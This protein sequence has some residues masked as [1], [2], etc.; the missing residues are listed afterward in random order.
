M[1]NYTKY[2]FTSVTNTNFLTNIK[3]CVLKHGWVVD[4]DDLTTNEEL[5]LHNTSNNYYSFKLIAS[6][7]EAQEKCLIVHGNTGFNETLAYDA[8]PGKFTE[9]VQT[10]NI[11]SQSN[12]DANKPKWQFTKTFRHDSQAF[13]IVDIAEQNIY[14][15][16]TNIFIVCKFTHT[17]TKIN[18]QKTVY[19]AYF[20]GK[21]DDAVSDTN[22]I[23][24]SSCWSEF[25][26]YNPI[27]GLQYPLRVN[28][29]ITSDNVGCGSPFYSYGLL[30]DSDNIDKINTRQNICYSSLTDTPY[31]REYSSLNSDNIRIPS[32]TL[33]TQSI[34]NQSNKIGKYNGQSSLYLISHKNFTKSN[35]EI[36]TNSQ[37]LVKPM[38][39]AYTGTNFK[40]VGNLPFYITNSKNQSSFTETAASIK[41]DTY[42]ILNI[43]EDNYSTGYGYTIPYTDGTV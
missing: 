6:N 40:I 38:I 31:Y 24:I 11:G 7:D 35:V 4:K 14:I 30:L 17:G 12:F 33:Y 13:W 20:I 23:I 22:S 34:N 29:S 19:L 16:S 9:L 21:L 1:E 36:C 42:D 10:I 2:T 37:Y 28:D 43:P 26:Y 18:T 3:T 15:N 32:Y 5:Y 27:V 41:Y 25:V 39:F 8:Q